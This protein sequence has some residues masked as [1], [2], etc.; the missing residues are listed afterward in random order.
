MSEGL[1][2]CRLCLNRWQ[3]KIGRNVKCV[4]LSGIPE[5]YDQEKLTNCGTVAVGPYVF[6]LWI[7]HCIADTVIKLFHPSLP[8]PFHR[9]GT[10]KKFEPPCQILPQQWRGFST[11][12]YSVSSLRWE[13]N[14]A[15]CF[16]WTQKIML[17]C[18]SY[19][20]S[21]SGFSVSVGWPGGKGGWES[22]TWQKSIQ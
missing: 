14:K 8:F 20:V 6:L 17:F 13:L 10:D 16:A 22:G 3:K 11:S 5:Y 7:R 4:V 19:Q 12:S 15:Q 1:N 2:G 21:V 9:W 18:V